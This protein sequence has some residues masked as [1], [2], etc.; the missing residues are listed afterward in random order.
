MLAAVLAAVATW[1]LVPGGGARRRLPAAPWRVATAPSSDP[2][3]GQA[4]ARRWPA[5]LTPARL[6][7]ATAGFAGARLVDGLLGWIGGA[8]VAW[9]LLRWFSVLAAAPK[10]RRHEQ[11]VRDLPVVVDLLVACLQ[12]GRAVSDCLEAVADAWPGPV[13]VELRTVAAQLALGGEPAAVWQAWGTDPALEPLA[14]AFARASRSGAS[15]STALQ[16][17]ATELRQVRRWDG[18]ARARSVGV[19]TAAPLG[20]CFMPAFIVLGVVPTVIGT[21]SATVL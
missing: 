6:A 3:V 14:R 2:A 20:L 5:W 12:A 9:G 4:L 13:G 17:A 7:A 8:L 19:R 21:F 10:Q 1:L 18:Q 15:I 16:H 11:M